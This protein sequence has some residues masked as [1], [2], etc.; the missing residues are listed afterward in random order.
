MTRPF[1]IELR[2]RRCHVPSQNLSVE[3]TCSTCDVDYFESRDRLNT[4][5]WFGLGFAL[6]WMVAAPVMASVDL[7][8]A[9]GRMRAMST[10]VPLLDLAVMTTVVAVLCG[11]GLL[12]L[13]RWFHRREFD[14]TP[15]ARRVVG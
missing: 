14:A 13:R 3:Y 4:G 12:G 9:A 15:A 1:Q 2:C 8:E 6:P 11:K 5:V 7:P 10:G